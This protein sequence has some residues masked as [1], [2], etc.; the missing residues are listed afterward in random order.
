MLYRSTRGASPEIK[1]SEVLLSGL[2]PDG[3]LYIPDCVPSFSEKELR[4]FEDYSYQDLA[5][6]IL[7]PF[8]E[9]EV[10]QV[11]FRRLVHSS[12][13]SFENN[14]IIKLKALS[15]DVSI[16][17]LFHG[18]TLAFKDIAMQLLGTLLNYFAERNNQKISVLGATSGDT[19]SSAIAACSRYENVDVFILYPNGRVTEIQRKQMT[20]SG[21]ANVH[22]LAIETDFDGCQDIVKTLFLDEE[23]K[24]LNNKVIA[25][26]SINW[27]RCMSQSVYFFWSFLKLRKLHNQITFSIPSGNFGHAYAGWLA[28]K[29]GLPIHRLLIATNRNDVLHKMLTENLYSKGEVYETLAPSM[30]ISIASNFERLLFDLFDN[31]PKKIASLMSSFPENSIRLPDKQLK[32]MRNFFTSYASSDAEICEQIRDTFTTN[33]MILDPHSA[34][35]VIA[36]NMKR[37]VNEYIISMATAHPAKFIHAI[38]QALPGKELEAVEQLKG[39]NSKKESFKVLANDLGAV[40][41]Y[42][43]NNII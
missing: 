5:S 17:E 9:D 13:E 36:S 22:A 18:P 39:I 14:D 15:D 11:T 8:V 23:I 40:K 27:T 3:G 30:D 29:M 33:N 7:Y 32:A 12:Y 2:A 34:T 4:E 43:L 38:E 16:L 28:K 6:K 35:G 21:S 42:I 31:N 37:E 41:E 1:F 24:N 10:D 19:G 26:N 20:T 25:A